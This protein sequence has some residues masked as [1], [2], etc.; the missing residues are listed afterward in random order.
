MYEFGA[1]RCHSVPFGAIRCW[2]HAA[3]CMLQPYSR[4]HLD[5][6]G[7]LAALRRSPGISGRSGRG[8]P[9]TT[10]LFT[11]TQLT[12]WRVKGK[13]VPNWEV[14]HEWHA[15][16]LIPR[17]GACDLHSQHSFCELSYLL[18]ELHV[19]GIVGVAADVQL[20][21][22]SR[23]QVVDAPGERLPRSTIKRPARWPMGDHDIYR[24]C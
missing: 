23:N 11:L 16:E 1:I 20:R 13:S 21:A 15:V 9:T 3:G 10:Q 2:L 4:H 8:T 17:A 24:P 18:A 5:L 12:R 7:V 6:L 22:D 14:H 19:V